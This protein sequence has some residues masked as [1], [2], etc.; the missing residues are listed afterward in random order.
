MVANTVSLTT[1]S[2]AAAP[3]TDGRLRALGTLGMIG[4]PFLLASLVVGDMLNYTAA[5]AAV[6]LLFTVGWFANVLGLL[7][8]EATGKRLPGKILLGVELVGVAL[9]N[10]FQVFEFFT[11]DAQHLLFT[12]TDIAWPLSMVVLLIIGITTAIVGRLQGAA[13]FIP[14]IAPLWLPGSILGS[15]AIGREAGLILG[16]VIATVGWFLT[17]YVVARGGRLG[18]RD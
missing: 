6:G 17:G 15:V 13:R 2:S 18:T 1:G 10:V 11:P 5:S 16:G 14:V 7:K 8:L 3:T 9:A 12:I 4:S